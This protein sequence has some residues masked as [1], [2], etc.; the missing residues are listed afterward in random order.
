MTLT[1]LMVRTG[2]PLVRLAASC[3]I[4]AGMAVAASKALANFRR[5]II[6]F[7]RRF[8][9]VVWAAPEGPADRPSKSLPLLDY[10]LVAIS[11]QD[12]AWICEHADPG[13]RAP[14]TA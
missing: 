6:S 14:L 1:S 8:S 10:D 5:F 9:I 13:H 7:F 4:A 3:A 12:L 2:S 11:V